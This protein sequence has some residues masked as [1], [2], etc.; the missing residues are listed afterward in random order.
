MQKIEQ[1]N[2]PA[3]LFRF[4]LSANLL[5]FQ[6]LLI[7]LKDLFLVAIK[8]IYYIL[9]LIYLTISPP[10]EKDLHG[11]VAVVT[12]GG[13]GIG[14]ELVRQLT[15]LGVK[16]AVWDINKQAA[17]EAVREIE[18]KK[19]LGIAVHVDV[20]DRLSI[21]KAVEVTRTELGEVTLL[22][23][24]AGIMPC[25]LLLNH[26]AT[27][28]ERLFNVNVMSHYWTI[29]EFLPRM[30]SLGR[31]HIVCMCSIAG[32]TGTPNLVPYC[33]SKFALKGLMDGLFHELRLQYPDSRVKTTRNTPT[34]RRCWARC[35]RSIDSCPERRS[36]C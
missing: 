36:W 29:F 11:E 21:Q 22:I 3:W 35:S 20:S 10:K 14:L 2:Q 26:S 17:D 13:Q 1:E 9:E 33:S 4:L 5:I 28:V 27:D 23:N 18:A 12:G 25:K 31:G 8:V 16:I 15:D 30:L 19:G 34:Y 32:I 6:P 24:N 7:T